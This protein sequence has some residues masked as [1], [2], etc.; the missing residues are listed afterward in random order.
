MKR[1]PIIC[2]LFTVFDKKKS[3]KNFIKNYKK[4][5][6][7]YQHDLLICYK[8]INKKK[9]IQLEKELLKIT[10]IKYED[11]FSQNDWDFGS[12]SRVA[13]KY[14]DRTIFFMNSHSYPIKN[15][16]LKKFMSHY[17]QKTIISSSG[18]YESITNQV[19]FKKPY[20][21]I[22]F[23][24]KKIKAKRAFTEFPNPHLN[25]ANFLINGND[26]YKYIKGKKF[27][28][29]YDTW[30]IESGFNSLTQFFK[31]KEFNLLVVNSEGKKF[32]ED[33]W[34]YSETYHYKNQ[35]KS[36]M[37]DKHSRK[38]LKYNKS[39]KL[40]SQKAVWGV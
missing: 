36:L 7:G 4:H 1:K 3:L 31:K 10:H 9:I 33:K 35:S 18:S 39:L 34:M 13:K 22:S 17:K 6:S 28:N 25:T 21:I 2:Y 30:K 19:K 5:K 16:W 12:Y 26:F 14:L 29:K 24:K 27:N 37:S 8:L 11:T 15:N 23:I 38:Y 20:N 32:P 40:I